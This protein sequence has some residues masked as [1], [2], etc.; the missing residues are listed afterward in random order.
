MVMLIYV[1]QPQALQKKTN[2]WITTTHKESQVEVI[3]YFFHTPVCL[4]CIAIVVQEHEKKMVLLNT[5]NNQGLT[6]W[7]DG[8]DILEQHQV[9]CT[10][11]LWY[12]KLFMGNYKEGE[13][14]KLL[15]QKL[16]YVYI[17]VNIF[18]NTQSILKIIASKCNVFNGL[19]LCKKNI[20]TMFKL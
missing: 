5:K 1:N 4:N 13:V 7:D 8:M 10:M 20:T 3:S 12:Q 9:V 15:P 18:V 17:I 2:E 6:S 19:C 11:K 16:E 14:L